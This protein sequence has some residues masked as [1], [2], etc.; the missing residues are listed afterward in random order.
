[1]KMNLHVN[2]L[3]DGLL[4]SVLLTLVAVLVYLPF[5]FQFG[6]YFDDWYIMFAAV[7]RGAEG[8]R[9]IYSIDRPAGALLM[10]PLYALFGVNPLFYN[11]S[12]FVFRIAS[13]FGVLTLCTM[14]WPRARASAFVTTLLFLIYPGF[15]SQPNGIVYQYYL[16]GLASAIWSIVLT[17]Q[18]VTTVHSNRKWFFHA[19]SILLGLFYLSQI[20][21][22]IGIETT[23]WACILLLGLREG[24]STRQK[25]IRA[26]QH[27]LPTLLIP[28]LFFT[29]RTFLFE[30][31]RGAT[32]VGLQLGDV[33]LYPIQTLFKWGISQ[34][35]NMF[36]TLIVAWVIPLQ[37]VGLVQDNAHRLA[38]LVIGV[39]SV[40]LSVAGLKRMEPRDNEI[41]ANASSW[42]RE[43]VWLGLTTLVFGIVPVTLANREVSFPSFSRYTL[44]ASLGVA[45]LIAVWLSGISKQR[46]R[47]S[48]LTFF[49]LASVL[50]H[51]GNGLQYANWTQRT[52][53]FWWQV[54]WRVP[55]FEKNTTL[56]ANI[57]SVAT[58][59][60]YFVW[61]P[62]NFIYY[63]ESQ[64]DKLV[65]PALYAA[66]LNQNTVQKVII[67]ERQ[68]YDNRR[69]II[70]YKNYRNILILSQ[71]SS[72]SCVHVI[73]GLQ[74]E[75]SNFESDSIRVI[76]SYSEM[77]HVLVDETSHTPPE[78]VFGT[79]PAHSW[80]YY[81]Q[82]A[83]LA[84]QRGEWE[85][86]VSLGN[87]AQESGYSP[88][89]AIEWMPFL[90]AY[91]VMGD[92]D[93][94]IKLAP[95]VRANLYIAQQVCQI[96][97]AMNE[98]S[99]P[100]KDLVH[101]EYCLE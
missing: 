42:K 72:N 34:V 36:E 35:Q 40:L 78:I 77:E 13:A 80:C 54:A 43:I 47:W 79:E 55:Q 11:L 3:P 7:T 23:R 45:M 67:R 29:W 19:L 58:E 86:I 39:I 100:V 1:M 61:G 24:G 88:S 30:N 46:A 15:L 48:I 51:Y 66:V 71:P 31:E 21:W 10:S 8:I 101:S 32:D 82:K 27:G 65:Q 52:S 33:F 70:T 89:D 90:Q 17:V 81:Y 16:A 18:A 50:T 49:V 41:H 83:D 63:P 91:A 97:N 69:G 99:D 59:E 53:D 62:A 38:G 60:D 25:I 14:L 93:R 92:I 6:Y 44:V 2:K 37:Q 26:L 75:F 64:N 95:T 96:L 4:I 12:A 68:E 5:V 84:R 98:L 57:N 85:S 74:P 9:E 22:Y 87:E 76:G 56:I 20:E 28:V 73:N 94:L